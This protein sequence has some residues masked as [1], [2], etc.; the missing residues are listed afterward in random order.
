[1][2]EASEQTVVAETP[3]EEVV[4]EAPKQKK[5]RK[6]PFT[7]ATI[8]DATCGNPDNFKQFEAWTAD[9]L[10]R[11]SKAETSDVENEIR[12]ESYPGWMRYEIT[13]H[14]VTFTVI[15]KKHTN[16]GYHIRDYIVRDH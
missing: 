1:M 15:A 13:V 2:T 7:L 12:K 6:A 5:P 9:Q 3:V 4:T 14:C 10:D 16:G 11:I 8:L